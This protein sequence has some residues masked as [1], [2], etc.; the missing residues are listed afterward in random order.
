MMEITLA[1]TYTHANLTH[2]CFY[3]DSIIEGKGKENRRTAYLFKNKYLL[4]KVRREDFL[5][6]SDFEG[7]RVVGID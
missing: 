3:K 7:K 2:I 5:L 4:G 6:L 1:Q